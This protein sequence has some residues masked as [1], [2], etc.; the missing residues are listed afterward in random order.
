MDSAGTI[1]GLRQRVLA[2]V[3]YGLGGI[4]GYLGTQGA[5]V[6]GFSAVRS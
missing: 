3:A 1:T 6:G 5:R 4:S 2:A